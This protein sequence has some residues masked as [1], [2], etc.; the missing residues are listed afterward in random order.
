MSLYQKASATARFELARSFTA[1]R[2]AASFILALFPPAMVMLLMVASRGGA[3][4]PEMVE[5]SIFILVYMVILLALLLWASPVVY[6]ELEGRTYIY[7]ASRPGGRISTMLGK[8][9]VAV[10]WSFAVA[11]VAMTLS[12]GVNEIWWPNPARTFRFW[13]GLT[14]LI[15]LACTVYASV[16]VLLGALSH[17]RAM[18]FCAGYVLLSEVWLSSL[19]AVI[20]RFT[21]R[22]HLYS[23]ADTM[24][25]LDWFGTRNSAFQDLFNSQPV[26][27]DLVMLATITAVSM[28]ATI[29]TLRTREYLTADEA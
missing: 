1:G 7:L 9:A 4:T 16:F 13:G 17:R 28:G 15:A 29:F 10:A 27:M 24:L 8:Y 19:P 23:L 14:I 11:W 2:I 18:V 21:V 5:F 25:A 12:L 26:W 3:R 20:N 6:A 22:F